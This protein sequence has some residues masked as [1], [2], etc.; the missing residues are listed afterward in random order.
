MIAPEIVVSEDTVTAGTWGPIFFEIWR[1]QGTPDTF[2]A[3]REA[4]LRFAKAQ[5]GGRKIFQF[6]T[7]NVVRVPSIDRDLHEAV[8]QRRRALLP[9]TFGA[10]TVVESTGFAG[11]ITRSLMATFSAVIRSSYPTA[12]CATP[13]QAAPWV[14]RQIAIAGASAT[15]AEIEAAHAAVARGGAGMAA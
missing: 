13:A 11:A 7:V 2:R 4:A 6:T 9:Y 15:A 14:S 1:D 5:P 3:L 10:V 8:T 12:V